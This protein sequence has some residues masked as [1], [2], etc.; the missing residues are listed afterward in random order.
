[1]NVL[2]VDDDRF[3]IDS[4][5]QGIQWETLGFSKVHTAYNITVAKTILAQ[6]QIDLLLSDIDMPYGSG[7]DLLFWIR[8]Q[9]N[10]IPVIFLTNYADFSYAQK[11]LSLKS[12]H[13]FLKPIAYEKLTVIIKEA[14]LQISQQSTHQ[15]KIQE[16]F[17]I[18]L[19]SDKLSTQSD[20][21]S[22]Y[23]S[24][25]QLPYV[26]DDLFLPI[27][28]EPSPYYLTPE[29]VLGSRFQNKKLM[30]QFFK[31]SFEAIF[32]DFLTSCELFIQYPANSSQ[33]LIILRLNQSEFPHLLPI[34]CEQL[35]GTMKSQTNC[36][37]NC[38]FGL[39]ST[40]PK[41]LT[42]Y[43]ALRS[44]MKNTLDCI[45]S[46]FQL[47][48]YVPSRSEYIPPDLGMLKIYL[49]TDQFQAFIESCHTYLHTLSTTG[50]LHMM[51]LNHFQID[52][53]QILYAFLESKNIVAHKLFHDSSYHT[54]AHNARNSIQ[55]MELYL[56]YMISI[57]QNHLTFSSSEKSVAQS[58]REYVD[59]NYASDISRNSLSEIFYLDPD[60]ASKLFKKETG[61]SFGN[62][63][64]QK[65]MDVAKHLLH[66]TRLPINTIADNVGYGNYSYFIRLFKKMTG[67]TPIEFR[68]ENAGE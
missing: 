56:Q 43:T 61:I 38:Y 29:N 16:H 66:T 41:F 50:C 31:T 4:L 57:S 55:N 3:V 6:E 23:I 33:Y 27:H 22:N 40:L 11:A 13:Y 15:D 58:I 7:L 20:S 37:L 51:A 65:R 62:Y 14:L 25:L 9:H 32:V 44:M 10:D 45:G 59:Q 42:S 17:W 63:I 47:A 67:F 60:Y 52:V 1:M 28:F 8:E 21:I 5:L 54:L 64:I 36:V 18:S 49:H 53:V 30:S 35:I 26:K 46:V 12:F 34:C 24:Q 39:P 68:N 2:L 19:L 48:N